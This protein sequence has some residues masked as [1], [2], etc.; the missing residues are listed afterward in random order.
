MEVLKK[1][2]NYRRKNGGKRIYCRREKAYAFDNCRGSCQQKVEIF[3]SFMLFHP[4]LYLMDYQWQA[5]LL[6]QAS[7]DTS[8]RLR[9]RDDQP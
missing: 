7:I 1:R 9:V 6:M 8:I 4:V 3:Y 5:A 2:C